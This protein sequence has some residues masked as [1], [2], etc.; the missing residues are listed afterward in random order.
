MARMIKR[1]PERQFSSNGAQL[2]LAEIIVLADL[3][4]LEGDLQPV[5]RAVVAMGEAERRAWRRRQGQ[6]RGQR[7]DAELAQG[8]ARRVAARDDG[9]AQARALDQR[10]FDLTERAP[11]GVT[12]ALALE[13]GAHI[14]FRTERRVE[15]D[16]AASGEPRQPPID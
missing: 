16:A 9:P 3:T 1:A 14:G 10:A 7:V 4:A 15:Y 8:V 5:E 11:N 12:R 6:A 13:L 2:D